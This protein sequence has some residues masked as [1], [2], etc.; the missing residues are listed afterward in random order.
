MRASLVLLGL[1]CGSLLLATV[2]GALSRD[3]R[4]DMAYGYFAGV[5]TAC[6]L[7]SVVTP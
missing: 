7:A 6:F 2:F 3:G 5:A 4:F 1:G